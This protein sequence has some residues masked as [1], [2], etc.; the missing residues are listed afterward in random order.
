MQVSA[1]DRAKVEE[2]IRGAEARTGADFV[3]VLAR[4]ASSYQ[5]YPLAWACCLALATPWVGLE[6]TTWPFTRILLAQFAV[7]A[8]AFTLLTIPALRRLIV[9][10]RVQ[11]AAAHRAAAE[12][13]LIRDLASTPSRRGILLF[14]AQEEH[15]ARVL[16]DDGV[17]DVLSANHWQ[18]CVALLIEHA[19][20]ERHAA[21]FVAALDHC[22]SELES[23]LPRSDPATRANHLPDRF[24][25]LG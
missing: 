2:A 24:H 13:F 8:A 19:R 4:N 23:V 22:A 6:L 14:V 9:P 15:Y 5:S 21:G 17:A 16:A 10:R 3:C 18:R 1:D 20:T 11:R 25:L 12:Q 7:F